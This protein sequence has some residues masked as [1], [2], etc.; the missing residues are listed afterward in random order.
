MLCF[1]WICAV[2]VTEP[3]QP[4][5][6][7]AAAAALEQA[8]PGPGISYLLL[9]TSGDNL[10]ERWPYP[11]RPVA[12]GSL[13]K[14]FLAVAYGEQHDGV[15]PRVQCKG[16]GS[17]C[18]LPAGHGSVRLEDAL[19]QS[20]NAYFLE[21]AA[22]LDRPRAARTFA[23]YGLTGP[24]LTSKDEALIGL[25]DGWRE[26][27]LSIASAYLLLQRGQRRGTEG[28]IVRGMQAAAFHGTARAVDAALG[29][30][31]RF[32]DGTALAK[33]GTAPCSHQPRGSA[34]GFAVVLYPAAQ[35]RLLLLVRLHDATGAE[36]AKLAGKMLRSLGA[37]AP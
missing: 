30:G 2:A 13:V 14:P 11:E 5:V 27:P 32:A 1:G 34:D 24:S 22:R 6:F 3:P 26:T 37:G 15:F 33:T 20:C 12:P 7:P 31:P 23:Q 4:G 29:A 9:S 8:F 10:A 21:L 18:W 25:G 17:R 36:T 28:R 16:M 19:A 35:P